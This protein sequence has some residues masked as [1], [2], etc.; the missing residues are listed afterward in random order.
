MFGIVFM[1]VPIFI[2]AVL[3]LMIISIGKQ[4]KNITLRTNYNSPDEE[5]EQVYSKIVENADKEKLEETRQKLKLKKGSI[6]GICIAILV[7]CILLAIFAKEL[8]FAIVMFIPFIGIF[9]VITFVIIY[10][11]T[12]KNDMI[13]YS[14]LYK[15]TVIPELVKS[16][17]PD[18]E[19]HIERGMER[20]IYLE[21]QFEGFDRYES[22]DLM[23]GKLKNNCEISMADIHTQIESR[24]SDGDTTYINLFSGIYAIVEIPKKFNEVLYIKKDKKNEGFSSTYKMRDGY[25]SYEKIDLDS[26]EF[27]KYFDVFGSNKIVAV[28]ILT[29]DVMQT[30]I[31]VREKMGIR[32]EIAI[33]DSKLYIRFFSGPMF[34]TPSYSIDPLDKNTIYKYYTM[35]KYVFDVA[36][37]LTEII[38]NTDY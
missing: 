24:D 26:Q 36:Y 14:R 35:L 18:V 38:E 4:S 11:F 7:I 27:E 34:E 29:S 16:M 31:E 15:N 17:E 13:L 12:K 2:I 32:Y 8:I 6:K 37:K 30:L 3:V 28:Q 33:R 22:D 21:S 19:Y 5:F 25:S 1:I 23:T 9:A 20:S 10:S